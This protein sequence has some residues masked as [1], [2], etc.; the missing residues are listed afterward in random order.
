MTQTRNERHSFKMLHQQYVDDF[1]HLYESGAI[2]LNRERIKLIDWLKRVVLVREEF[3]FDEEQIE[4][5]ISFI[6]KYYFVVLPWQRFL[7]AFV[8]LMDSTTDD[9]VFDEHFWTMARGAGKNGII[10]GIS[11]YFISELHGVEDYNGAITA[12]NLYQAEKSFLQIKDT[13]KRK[14]PDLQSYFRPMAAEV[15]G[16]DTNSSL[17]IRSGS[18]EGKDSF[19]DGFLIFDEVHESEQGEDDKY[20]NQTSG[21]GKTKYSRTFYISTNGFKREGKYD[22]LVKRANKILESDNLDDPMFPWV[23]TLDHAKEV[24][25][26]SCWQKA[27]PMFHEPMSDYAKTLF[28]TVKRQWRRLES[29]IGNKPKWL[30]KRMNLIGVKLSTQVATQAEI[31]AAEREYGNLSD[32]PCIGSVDFSSVKDFTALGLLF[33]R[34]EEYIWKTHSFVLRK[35]LETEAVEAPIDLW[36][37]QELLT[38]VDGNLI[39]EEMVVDWFVAQREHHYFNKVIIDN[40]RESTLKPALEKV[41]FEVIVIRRSPGVQAK[42]GTFIETLFAKKLLILGKPTMMRW[43]TWNVKVERDT[44][45][46]ALFKKRKNATLKTDGFMAMIHALYI[47]LKEFE[48]MT[49]D[50]PFDYDDSWIFTG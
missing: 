32:L 7:I 38:K 10:S 11:N 49:V 4:N 31:E 26:E 23:C 34:E 19:A 36:E 6:E 24:E 2:I 22:E 15:I 25:D 17:T 39:T 46:N 16:I 20:E 33:K 14:H 13:I 29:G 1:F 45:G 41:G 47:S 28:N 48:S 50:D 21:L 37:E 12:N 42:I 8:F 9:L 40:Y 44:D 27:N 43:Y 18:G 5:C 30:T 35:Y 3:Y